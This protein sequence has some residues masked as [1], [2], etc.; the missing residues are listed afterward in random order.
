M[1]VALAF[2]HLLG[3]EFGHAMVAA[4]KISSQLARIAFAILVGDGLGIYLVNE[5][6]QAGGKALFFGLAK[7]SLTFDHLIGYELGHAMVAAGK[8]SSQ[9]ARIAFTILVGD[10]LGVHLVNSPLK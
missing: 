8:V 1:H 4:G 5:L 10:G 7:Q 2:D 6:L 3:H 9:L